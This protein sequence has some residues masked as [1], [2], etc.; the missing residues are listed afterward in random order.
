MDAKRKANGTA[1]SDSD[2]RTS[3]RRKDFDLSKGESRES[4]TAYGLSFLDQIRRTADKSGRLVATYFEKLLPQDGNEEYYKQT[5]MP[6]SLE[7]IEDKLNNGRFRT[8][9]ELESYFKRMISNAKEFYPRSS[10]VFDD[11]ERVRKALSNYMTKTNPAYGTRGY[12]AQPTPLP[13]E[14]GEEEDEDAE[15][16]EEKQGEAEAE[17]VDAEGEDEEE[18]DVGRGSRRRSIVLKRRETV[19]PSRNSTSQA[20]ESPRLSIPPGKPDH[21]YD[22]VPYKGLSFQQAQEKIVEELLRYYEPDYEGYFEPFYNLPPRALKDY[23]RVITDPLSLKKL[24][25]SIKGVHGRGEATGVS[26]YKSW[27][28]FE[29]KSKLLWTNAYFYN[30]EG[31]EIYDL[32][33]ELEE[34]FHEELKKARAVVQEPAQPPKIK[35]KVGQGTETPSS[36]KK[37]TIHV[38]GRGGSADSPAPTASQFADTPAGGVNGVTRTSSRL[39]ATRSLSASVPSPSPSAQAGFKTEEM[40]LVSPAVVAQP[41]SGAPA[42][43]RPLVAAIPPY[44]LPQAVPNNPVINGYVEQRRL[45]RD[46]KGINDALISRL[47]IQLHP[48]MQVEHSDVLTVFPQSKELQQFVTVNLPP[49]YNR[50]FIVPTLPDF[51]YNRQYSLW[52][53]IDKQPLKPC[54]QVLPNQL[55]QERAFE[56]VLHQGVNTIEAHLIAAIPR[57]E[58][59]PGGPE[60]ELEVFTV[61]AN[62]LRS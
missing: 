12:Q 27:S 31:S 14:D 8:L 19:R 26:D 11:A 3:K 38:G 4:T 47:R 22:N 52:V 62:V 34:A 55:P 21:Q 46:G 51:L 32:A 41:P 48:N 28:A 5:R 29:E 42:A 61:F 20:Q 58:R 6:I 40:A 23:Y 9:A 15:G 37:I 44:P 53:M 30:E 25:K 1:T 50:V 57:N 60:A 45:R 43:A 33:Q 7:T 10:S 54:M 49:H 56:V 59:E 13:P 17:D 39:D 36:S 16:E 2:D 18:E 24:Q 35:L